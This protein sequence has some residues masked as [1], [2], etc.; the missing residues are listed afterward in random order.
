MNDNNS[1][2]CCSTAML[3]HLSSQRSYWFCGHCRLE[4][5]NLQANKNSIK[6]TV[7]LKPAPL[8]SAIIPRKSL[9][10]IAAF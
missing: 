9:E 6:P 10:T 3:L 8:K 7:Q 2:P 1:C 4:M 5:P